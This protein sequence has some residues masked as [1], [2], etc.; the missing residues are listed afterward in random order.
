MISIKQ[1]VDRFNQYEIDR[2][3]ILID[4]DGTRDIDKINKFIKDNNKVLLSVTYKSCDI[5]CE[6]LND[7]ENVLIIFDEFHNFSYNNIY[8]EEDSINKL[9]NNEKHNKLYLSATPRIYELE[10]N[11]D[12]DVN[13]IFGN[14]IYKMSFNEAINEKY[15]SDYEVYLPIFELKENEEIKSLNIHNDYLQKIQFLIEGIKMCGNLKIIVY[16]RDHKEITNFIENFNKL[17][18]YYQYDVN[19]SSITCNESYKKRDKILDDFNKSEKIS[20]LLSNHILDEA[21]DIRSCN[22]IYM[23]YISSSKIKNIQRARRS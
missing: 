4:S 17:N 23:T 16:V 9:I 14:Y 7:L 11:D 2:R 8:N 18:E 20:I 3:T 15:I 1:N 10:N 5:I 19:I 6:I 12:I 21:I 22:S 13:D